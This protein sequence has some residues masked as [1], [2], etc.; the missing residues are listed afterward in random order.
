MARE[1]SKLGQL[2]KD[3][4][5]TQREFAERVFTETGYFIA[6]SN[7]CNYCSGYKTLKKVETA[8]IFAKVLQVPLEEIL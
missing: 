3:R 4:G 5:M 2:I 8:K 6:L 1:K 7:L